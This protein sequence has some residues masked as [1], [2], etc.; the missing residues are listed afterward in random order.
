MQPHSERR[1]LPPAPATSSQPPQQKTPE[2][3]PNLIEYYAEGPISSSISATIPG[4][5]PV[6]VYE[7]IPDNFGD[8]AGSV[9][10]PP[11]ATRQMSHVGASASLLSP[12]RE[13][14]GR[15][16]LNGRA[17]KTSPHSSPKQIRKR[18]D[19]E[20]IPDGPFEETEQNGSASPSPPISTK[21]GKKERQKSPLSFRKTTR[22]SPPPL[23]TPYKPGQNKQEPTTKV[24]NVEALYAVVDK[25]AKTSRQRP[26]SV[27]PAGANKLTRRQL[28]SSNPN[29]AELDTNAQTPSFTPEEYGK[30]SHAN[31]P[32]IAQTPSS[33]PEEY[34]K[35]SHAN[36]PSIIQTPEEYGRLK[37]AQSSAAVS[38]FGPDE[39]GKLERS[40]EDPTPTQ[41]GRLE[42]KA[43][44]PQKVDGY[45]RLGT[46]RQS[47]FDP[48]GTLTSEE[49]EKQIEEVKILS[50]QSSTNEQ[51]PRIKLSGYETMEFETADGTTY[52]EID[53]SKS[54][55]NKLSVE[56]VP[57]PGYENTTL[58]LTPAEQASYKAP[59]TGANKPDSPPTPPRSRSQKHG[60]VN[61]NEDGSIK[62]VEHSKAPVVPKRNRSNDSSTPSPTDGKQKGLQKGHS[63]EEFSK[64]D[65][66][67]P[68]SPPKR[69]ASAHGTS[70]NRCSPPLAKKLP[71]PAA[72][73]PKV[74][75]TVKPK[76]VH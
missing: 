11:E 5:N 29:L 70:S 35:L 40:Q 63:L 17:G 21:S 48:Y 23:P 55:K 28:S 67:S 61:I 36:K 66:L 53:D 20:D 71:P 6:D 73:K 2:D 14:F 54:V 8:E 56:R 12:Q 43:H 19:Y 46:N 30:L 58:K 45:G 32:S 27:T 64:N 62:Q 59:S 76:P 18:I 1:P 37:H 51:K 49:L 44:S 69:G 39:Y 38:G 15:L 16:E 72:P 31:K 68:P 26:K 50:T 52:S 60:Y 65:E 47:S 42:S 24:S 74:K 33:T 41:Y 57:P 10:Y 3:I 22:K 25:S 9:F 7:D 13:K 4:F 75:P 34:G